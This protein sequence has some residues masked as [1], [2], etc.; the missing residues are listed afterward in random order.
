MVKQQQAVAADFDEYIFSMKAT[1]YTVE[2]KESGPV[3]IGQNR[4]RSD[5]HYYYE[6]QLNSIVP[7][8]TS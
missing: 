2:N 6:N 1:T 8:A 4:A 3:T 7:Q 5:W